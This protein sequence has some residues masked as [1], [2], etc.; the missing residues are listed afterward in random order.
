M[1]ENDTLPK[2]LL[3]HARLRGDRPAYREKDL[4]IWQTWSW[5]KTEKE[6]RNLSCGLKQL[7]FERGD[8][9]AIIGDNRP[10]LYWAIMAAQCLGGIPVPLYQDSV[11]QEM[12]YVLTN[13]DIRF[14]VVENQEQTD[15]LLEIRE[16]CPKLETIIYED[17]RGMNAYQQEFLHCFA[18][19]QQAGKEFDQQNNDFFETSIAQVSKSDISIILYTSGTTGVPKGV[20]LSQDNLI[21]ASR[22]SADFDHLTSDEEVLAYL[23]MAWVGDNVFSIGQAYVRGFCVN[24][25]ENRDTVLNDLKEIGPTYYFAPPAVFESILTRVMIRME[26]AGWIKRKMFN[27]FMEHS[28]NVGTDILDKKPVSLMDR[29]IYALGS[30][31]VYEPL[32]NN[33]GFTR[34]K[35]AY[36]AGEAIG[37]E[38]FT[39]FR[40]LG[41]NIK[42]LYGQTE[43]TVFVCIQP[44]GEVMADTVGKAAPGVELKIADDGEV[45]YRS[46]GVFQ[47]YF[48][49]PEATAKTK[50]EE[51][52]VAT[53]DAGILQ[54]NGHLMII[55]RA[56]D[57]GK[58]KDGT[59]FAPKYL[60]NKLKFF[61]F[62]K[63]VVTFGKDMDF[64]SAFVCIDMEA[65]GNWA[66]RRNLA[67]SGYTDLAS[68]DEIYDLIYECVE[69]VNVDLA[70][71]D[72]LRGS[73]ILRFLILHKELD[74][75]DGELTRTRKVRRNIISER[76]QPLIDALLDES[77]THCSIETEMTFEDGRKG[78]VEADLRIMNLQKI[79]TPVHAKAA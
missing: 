48:K 35:L 72:K 76:Y 28:R 39:F 52:W 7:G 27:Y 29:L 45:F 54:E 30:L 65:V 62:I 61:P 25:P 19:V 20:V 1:S 68:R 51:G 22:S 5:S 47:E 77:K 21:Q 40:S 37:P 9:L 3:E 46:A 38:I 4:G 32:K 33:L 71:D 78:T 8:K 53:G 15:K 31:L 79:N 12:K 17:T 63:E 24:C 58:M 49:N 73:Q 2:L 43:A 23:P 26:D 6:I 18:D 41:I 64:A 13:A 14:A 34:L 70:R 74:A 56:K 75:D 60:E 69:S 57:V 11:A 50:S 16:D 36:T 10:C 59:L 67:Y 42:Q 44:D 55:D 66:E